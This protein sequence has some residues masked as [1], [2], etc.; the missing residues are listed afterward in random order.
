MIM[1]KTG[2]K[3]L[4]EM[5][6]KLRRMRIEIQELEEA[7]DDCEIHDN[8]DTEYES[9]RYRDYNDYEDRDRERERDRDYERRPRTLY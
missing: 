9:R 3:S 4:S 8:R 1:I 7:I 5:K 6:E 2:K